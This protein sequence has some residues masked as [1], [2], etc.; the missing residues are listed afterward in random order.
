MRLHL[1][2]QLPIFFACLRALG[3]RLLQFLVLLLRHQQQKRAHLLHATPLH[4]LHASRTSHLLQRFVS[5]PKTH[6]SSF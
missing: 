3:A 4:H 6:M 2:G 1:G 5:Y